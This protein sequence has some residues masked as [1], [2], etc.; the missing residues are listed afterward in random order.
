MTIFNYSQQFTEFLFHFVYMFRF[1]H[2]TTIFH[3]TNN[4]DFGFIFLII[5]KNMHGSTLLCVKPKPLVLAAYLQK[6][7]NH[8]RS[9]LRTHTSLLWFLHNYF[10]TLIELW[11]QV[12]PFPLINWFIPFSLIYLQG[13]FLPHQLSLLLFQFVT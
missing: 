5:S 1:Y 10:H 3:I 8:S 12:L 13:T 7:T 2:N 9:A 4:Y 6:L 11:I